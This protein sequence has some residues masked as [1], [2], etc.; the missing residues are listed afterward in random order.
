MKKIFIIGWKDLAL[1]LRDRGALILML[2]APFVLTLGLGFVS[3]RFSGQS[4]VS[5]L[6]DIPVVVV[7]HDDGELGRALA[8]VFASDDLADLLD[9]ATA[10][11]DAEA[12]RQVD[13]DLAAA[14]VIIPAG[15]SSSI[16]PDFATGATTPDVAVELYAN[17]ARP[18]GAGVIETIVAGFLNEVQTT[19]ITGRVTF[20]QLLASGRLAPDQTSAAVAAIASGLLNADSG[21]ALITLQAASAAPAED[22]GF[23]F[24][25]LAFFAPGMAMFFLMYTVTHGGRSL[26]AERQGGTLPRLLSTPTTAA[27]VLGGKVFGIYLTGAAQVGVLVLA[28]SLL[29]RLRWGDPLGVVALILAVAAAAT[30]WGLLLA[31]FARTP[32]QVGSLGSALMLLFGIL[33]G[34][35]VPSGGF[36]GWLQAVARVTPNAWGLEGFTAL[37]RGGMLADLALPLSA[38]LLMAAVLFAA[39]VLVFRRAGLARA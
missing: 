11:G 5:G 25:V 12:R 34:S 15:F 35:F 7:N 38:L 4:S 9:P 29:F 14:A 27:Q 31:A 1:V 20:D 30:G 21:G 18:V 8:A 23:E 36:P 28:S 13:D 19:Q 33:G 32:A 10:A 26:L 39:A 37:A 16:I 17:P 3:G 6:Q 24:D 2:A 22:P